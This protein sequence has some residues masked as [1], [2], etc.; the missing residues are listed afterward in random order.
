M[1]KSGQAARKALPSESFGNVQPTI[2]LVCSWA[3][4]LFHI[5]IKARHRSLTPRKYTVA[6]LGLNVDLPG[7]G[8][9]PRLAYQ[10]CQGTLPQM[11]GV[12]RASALVAT[13]LT[14]S[15][16][17]EVSSRST[18]SE[19]MAWLARSPARLGSDWVS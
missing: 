18:L 11:T 19:R 8:L 10:A 7:V 9:P 3:W 5:A 13:G 15:G 17:E 12:P 2:L 6:N 1:A 14:V 16:V 4:I